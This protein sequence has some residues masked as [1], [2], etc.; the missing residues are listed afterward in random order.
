MDMKVSEQ[1]N[2][3]QAPNKGNHQTPV[4]SP[5]TPV[6]RDVDAV[7]S[8]IGRGS[9]ECGNANLRRV[10]TI[11]AAKTYQ[12]ASSRMKIGIRT[13]RK[14]NKSSNTTCLGYDSQSVR[15]FD[16]TLI[17]QQHRGWKFELVR[18][19]EIMN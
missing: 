10:G 8:H 14:R 15:E 11:L 7:N 16:I 1:T 19:D 3:K 18:I 5:Q 4:H 17:T 2:R 9:G 6:N 12:A 13:G